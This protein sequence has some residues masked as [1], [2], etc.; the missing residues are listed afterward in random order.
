MVDNKLTEPLHLQMAFYYCKFPEIHWH[1]D[2]SKLISNKHCDLPITHH[3]QYFQNSLTVH[4]T[5][6][7]WTLVL[8]W[9]NLNGTEIAWVR[10]KG[11]KVIWIRSLTTHGE[12]GK[13]KIKEN[14]CGLKIKVYQRGQVR[15]IMIKLGNVRVGF[16]NIWSRICTQK[17]S[18]AM[19]FP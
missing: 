2:L 7:G 1:Q 8:I 15:P 10:S 18:I 19:W 5:E 13:L 6:L 9:L 17:H 14:S 4:L 3:L 11:P 12:L 16:K